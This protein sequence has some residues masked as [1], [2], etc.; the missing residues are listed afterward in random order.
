MQNLTFGI[1]IETIG[2]SRHT[3]AQA[4]QQ[5]V[6]GRIEHLRDV[7]DTYQVIDN[8]GRAWQA[9][10]DASLSSARSRQAELVSPILRYDDI[11]E[12]QEVVR[13][14]RRSGA[15]VDAS[16]GIHIHVGSA[17][18]DAKALVNLV[19]MVNK[20]EQLIEHAL[21]VSAARRNRWCRSIDSRFIEN[22]ERRRPRN[23][24]AINAAWYGRHNN[25]PRHYDSSRYRGVNLHSVWYRGTIEF[26]WF[27]ATLHAGKV[28]A[29]IQFIL[30]LASKALTSRSASSAKREFNPA[31]AKY[32]FR[33]FLLRLGMIGD[34]FKTA[35]L[36]LL[37]RFNG[38]SAWKH[39]RPANPTRQAA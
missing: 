38:S 4:I 35:R 37:S 5:V 10:S 33:V 18:F 9:K 17:P 23:L 29:Y 30:A 22:L 21:G 26:R 34:E 13:S 36:H 25:R 14:I 8:R 12:L 1:E 15:K 3:V 16:C 28:K 27:D 32:D 39:G 7:Y 24:D 2:R 11:P 6:G 31:T 19:K 20:Q